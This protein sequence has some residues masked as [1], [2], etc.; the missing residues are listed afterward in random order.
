M[1]PVAGRQAKGCR[2]LLSPEMGGTAGK[3]PVEIVACRA[4]WRVVF[5]D[6]LTQLTLGRATR[7]NSSVLAP[8]RSGPPHRPPSHPTPTHPTQAWAME[9]AGSAETADPTGAARVA[10]LH[11][12]HPPRPPVRR[13]RSP[14]E[15]GSRPTAHPPSAA[16]PRRFPPLPQ[17]RRRGTYSSVWE[18]KTRPPRQRQPVHRIGASP[19]AA[20]RQSGSLP[21]RVRSASGRCRGRRGDRAGPSTSGF[22]GSGASETAG[23]GVRLGPLP[24]PFLSGLLPPPRYATLAPRRDA[25]GSRSAKPPSAARATLTPGHPGVGRLV[26]RGG[27]EGRWMAGCLRIATAAASAARARRRLQQPM[28]RGFGSGHPHAWSLVSG[29]CAAGPRPS[30]SQERRSTHRPT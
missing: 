27:G 30:G 9:G 29:L 8:S 21:A 10:T 16:H 17:P 26:E 11:C 22:P 15:T 14:L 7:L 13:F 24:A 20:C 18:G 12:P 28:N 5:C 23:G 19:T 6:G 3:G 2:T 25:R 1:D 4:S